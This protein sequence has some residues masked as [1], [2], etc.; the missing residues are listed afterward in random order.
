MLVARRR[1]IMDVV[2]E[3]SADA[4]MRVL[5]QDGQIACFVGWRG[6]PM[7]TL[8]GREGALEAGWP[9]WA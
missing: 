4:Y 5:P 2:A 1:W 3:V 8:V 7:P 9:I 6:M